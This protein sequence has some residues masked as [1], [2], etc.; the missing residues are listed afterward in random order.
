MRAVA[1]PRLKVC[2]IMTREEAALAV[3]AGAD[4]V[5][6]VSAMPSGPGVIGDETIALIARTVPPPVATFLLT[7]RQSVAGIVAQ[8]RN[9]RTSVIQ[10][11]DALSE[12][13]FEELR[14][15]LPGVK[16]VQVIHVTGPES[17]EDAVRV[18]G[19]VDA[20]LLDSGRPAAAVKELGGTGRRHDWS[21][22]RKIREALEIPLF[23]AGGLHAGNVREAIEEVGPFG[24]DVCS[25]VRTDGKL[26]AAKLESLV[27]AIQ[28]P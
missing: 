12:G 28:R 9:V 1:C 15:H 2:C 22:S 26:D 14:T 19:D 24:L 20:V 7:S 16:L 10:I 8:H 13:T 4:A 11:V 27:I 25:G 23:L 5:G 17:V 18:S 6:L 3:R 21:V